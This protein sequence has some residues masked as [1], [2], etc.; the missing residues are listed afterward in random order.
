MEIDLLEACQVSRVLRAYG[1]A[2]SLRETLWSPHGLQ[3]ALVLSSPPPAWAPS[4]PALLYGVGWMLPV[5]SLPLAEVQGQQVP[6]PDAWVCDSCHV[7]MC[8]PPC[9]PVM[10]VPQ[11]AS[12]AFERLPQ[13]Q[14]V[15]VEILTR[16]F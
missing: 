13:Y 15:G 4:P 5:L 1:A 9:F 10:W 12:P 11:R 7:M 8:I 3:D 6:P 14:R 2:L 16:I